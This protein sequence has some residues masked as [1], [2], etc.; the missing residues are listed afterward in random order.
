MSRLGKKLLA[1][2]KE[3][4]AIARGEISE[5]RKHSLA[6]Y[7]PEICQRLGSQMR[8][9]YDDTVTAPLPPRLLVQLKRLDEVM[10]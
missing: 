6:R 2:A 4:I 5:P 3:G 10:L 9:R 7:W 1:G 8:A